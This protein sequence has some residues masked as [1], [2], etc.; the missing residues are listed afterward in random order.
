VGKVIQSLGS[1]A[2]IAELAKIKTEE[3]LR[4]QAYGHL[5]AGR[6]DEC[7]RL[8]GN[9][10]END[11]YALAYRLLIADARKD[12]SRALDYFKKVNQSSNPPREW[13]ERVAISFEAAND[14]LREEKFDWP[15]GDTPQTGW[16]Y[17][18]PGTGIR[19]HVKDGKM[20]F[21]GTQSVTTD[22]V[23]HAFRA[24]PQ[25]RLRLF[26]ATLY[27]S[28]V[29]GAT[30]GLEVLDDS[31][32]GFHV[33]VRGDGHLVWRVVKGPG[34]YA[35]WKQLDFQNQG[36]TAT[37]AIEYASGRVKVLVGDD[38]NNKFALDQTFFQSANPTAKL[39]I[40]FFGEAEAG[41]AWK[42][43]VDDMQVQL[44][45]AGAPDTGNVKGFGP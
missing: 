32:Q 8:L 15:E 40:G 30:C 45:P 11:G 21:E 37:L 28:E 18:M 36:N 31:M 24:E 3:S 38:V 27:L 1:V 23:S 35:P 6:F 7:E 19:I 12:K 39:N 42:L 43:A 16:L 5:L 20:R 14:E 10:L 34:A 25:Q 13:M 4:W 41:Q 29:K 9:Q 26:R 22:P 33:A 17:K 44:R 2:S